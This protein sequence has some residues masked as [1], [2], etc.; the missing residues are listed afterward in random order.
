MF[1]VD[2]VFIA[3]PELRPYFY[4]G[5]EIGQE[6]PRYDKVIAVADLMLDFFDFIVLHPKDI[7][8]TFDPESW[9]PYIKA[10]LASSP[11]LRRHLAELAGTG[12]SY[13]LAGMLT[14]DEV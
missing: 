5:K 10:T 8:G 12:H 11:V 13:R 4:S 1:A 14:A 7:T 3:E 2:Q 9:I 6:D